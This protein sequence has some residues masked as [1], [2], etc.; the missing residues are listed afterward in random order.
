MWE[1]VLVL[2]LFPALVAVGVGG[3]LV[4]RNGEKGAAKRIAA[5]C[6]SAFAF[7][8]AALYV[9]AVAGLLFLVWALGHTGGA[10]GD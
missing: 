2:L 3:L 1:S 8:G 6:V 9:L 4:A 7:G 10:G 5:A